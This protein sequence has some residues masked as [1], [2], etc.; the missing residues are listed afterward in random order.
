MLSKFANEYILKVEGLTKDVYVDDY[1]KGESIDGVHFDLDYVDGEYTLNGNETKEELTDIV[2]NHLRSKLYHDKIES[3]WIAVSDNRIILSMTEDA[4]AYP[5]DDPMKYFKE[6]KT[7]YSCYYDMKVSINGKR[8]EEDDL[9][10][11]FNF[12]Y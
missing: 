3:D 8:L 5:I 12:T 10:D 1:E 9:L 6:G 11:L 2:V 7:V 4:D